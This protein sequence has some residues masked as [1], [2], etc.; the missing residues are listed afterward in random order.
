[1]RKEM[2]GWYARTEAIR[3]SVKA[4]HEMAAATAAT[5]P[6][7]EKQAADAKKL[8]DELAATKSRVSARLV[9]GSD[10][11]TR[12][13]YAQGQLADVLKGAGVGSADE[14]RRKAG[15]DNTGESMRALDKVLDLMDMIKTA[16]DEI[17]TTAA[18]RWNAWQDAV[19]ASAD[20]LR[21]N[22]D[23]IDRINATIA[24]AAATANQQAAAKEALAV[25]FIALR[26]TRDGQKE[27]ADALV[28][29]IA[30]RRD[31]ADLAERTG[32]SEEKALAA[33]REKARL[34]RSIAGGGGAVEGGGGAGRPKR[35]QLGFGPSRLNGREGFLGGSA[36][37]R[38]SEI[39][40]RT[41]AN[42]KL[43]LMGKP[44]SAARF[45]ERQLDLQQKLVSHLGKLGLA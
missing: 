20:E 16:S 35:H 23:E 17:G 19:A 34:E 13:A 6:T 14:L 8:A 33:L 12:K 10:A 32:L 18:G 9:A 39:E 3:A 31:A 28:A 44:E 1:M 5:G 37:L 4:E 43:S 36:S 11:E 7:I 38:N 2:A 41:R 27:K 40:R 24:G 26:M 29:E 42:H 25:E 30:M 21:R 15:G 45:W 22:K